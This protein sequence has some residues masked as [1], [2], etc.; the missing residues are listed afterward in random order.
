MYKNFSSDPGV[1][2]CLNIARGI[3]ECERELGIWW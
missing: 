3:V 2:M 1:S